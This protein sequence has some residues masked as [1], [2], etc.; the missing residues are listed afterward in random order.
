MLLLVCYPTGA[1]AA[2]NELDR[3]LLQHKRAQAAALSAVSSSG[4]ARVRRFLNPSREALEQ[5]PFGQRMRWEAINSFIQVRV[6]VCEHVCA[7][8]CDGD[9]DGGGGR[10]VMSVQEQRG[11]VRSLATPSMPS[12]LACFVWSSRGIGGGLDEGPCCVCWQRMNCL[13]LISL[14]ASMP[15]CLP[16]C[17]SYFPP[18]CPLS[19]QA[20]K[21]MLMM[22]GLMGIMWC[23]GMLPSQQDPQLL[24]A[25]LQQAM[26]AQQ[27]AQGV[28]QQ[29][30]QQQGHGE[31]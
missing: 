9:G 19:P 8:V 20:V 1:A 10:G 29:A 12:M 2:D 18:F 22:G 16:P 23:F 5:M 21:I 31:L 15:T 13:H 26:A 25:R 4:I 30:E 7:R 24:E 28:Q 17:P 14:V 27:G 3:E 11:L 6:C